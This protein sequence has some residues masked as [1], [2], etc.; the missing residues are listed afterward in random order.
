M[1]KKRLSLNIRLTLIQPVFIA[2]TCLSLYSCILIKPKP[3]AL[4]QNIE[5]WL[6][7]NEFDKIDKEID[8]IDK[9]DRQYRTILKHKE[10]IGLKKKKFIE[11]TSLKAQKYKL[12]N[13]WQ[14]ALDTYNNA[15][16]KIKNQPILA[17]EKKALISER[18]EQV[19][20]LRKDMLMKQAD[21]LISYKKI[22]EKLHQL[23]PQDLNAQ[24]DIG[25]YDKDRV[26]VASHLKLCGEHAI[27]NKQITLARDCFSLSNQLDP[28][29]DKQLWVKK[30]NKQLLD[31]A[32]QK[33]HG[34]LLAA[35]NLAYKNGEYN[36]AKL[37]LYTLLAIDPSH[38][39]AKNL[40]QSIN[41]EIRKLALDKI[42]SGRALYAEKKIDGAL[43]LWKEALKL[44]PENQE[45]IQLISRAEK[46]SKK[47]QSL[48]ESQ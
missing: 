7:Q 46:V 37:H 27:D 30:T 48:E 10:S 35:Y 19:T 36:K 45:L 3:E 34:E 47:I 1:K 25:R 41:S 14:L 38:S 15:L 5:Q 16:E 26:E 31:K 21:A 40:L 28:S 29:P 8:S 42:D 6:S 9:N 4:I 44:E 18:D 23:I 39:N 2:L 22:Y 17:K 20:A 24:F 32:K 13:E 33:R 43:K 12:S 11:N